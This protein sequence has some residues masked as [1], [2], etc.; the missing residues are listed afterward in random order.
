MDKRTTAFA[1]RLHIALESRRLLGNSDGELAKLLARH[2]VAVSPQTISNWRNGKHMPKLQQFQGLAALLKVDPGELAFGKPGRAA[3]EQR[4]AWHADSS[5]D[6]T[7]IVEAY[8]LLDDSRRTLVRE[9]IRLL[10]LP[11]KSGK[12]PGRRKSTIADRKA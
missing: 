12:R 10:S 11:G 7:E 9:L 2:H 4:G 8:A 1:R 5:P 3:G 6:E